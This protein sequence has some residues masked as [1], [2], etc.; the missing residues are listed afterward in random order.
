MTKKISGIVIKGKQRGRTL[1]FPTANVATTGMK[2]ASGVY[3]GKVHFDDHAYPVAIF[4]GQEQDV[5]EA[6]IIGFTEDLYG[7]KIDV[8]IGEKLRE[9]KKFESDEAL[10]KQIAEDVAS[11]EK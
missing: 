6:H 3:S 4:V 7:R 11:I 10:K 8:E 5:L 2:I 9:T 1:G